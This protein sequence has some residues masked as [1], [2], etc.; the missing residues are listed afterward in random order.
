MFTNLLF[1]FQTIATV[2]GTETGNISA[3]LSNS[4]NTPLIIGTKCTPR[5]LL[6]SSI[7][8]SDGIVSDSN[9][10]TMD[11]A[12]FGIEDES[13][14]L[15]CPEGY[16]CDLLRNTNMANDQ[17]FGLCKPCA[18]NPTTCP[19]VINTGD[20][21]GT[22][23][24][25]SKSLENAFVEECQKQ[26]GEEKNSC[27]STTDC[28]LGL[29]C[30]FENAEQGGY[31]EKCPPHV[32]ICSLEE[33][34]LSS[35][36]LT[37]CQSSCAVQ[38]EPLGAFEIIEPATSEITDASISPLMKIED[39]NAMVGSSQLEATG[40]VFD[41]GLGLKPCEG[42]EGS[43]C[44][45]ERGKAPFINKTR[46]CEAGGGIAA[47]IYN[48]EANCQNFPGS[49]FGQQSYIPA[50]SL[51]H[52]DG[53][54]ILNQAEAIPLETPL[55]VTVNVGGRNSNPKNCYAGCTKDIECEGK[56]I[57]NFKSGEFGDCEAIE[58]EKE[59]CNDRASFGVDHLKCSE[60]GEFCDFK[61]G[62]RGECISCPDNFESCF[63]LDLSKDGAKEC[64]AV[65]TDG[66]S[67]KIKSAPCKFCQ[68]GTYALGELSDGFA[69]LEEEVSEP[70]Q[71]CEP[72]TGSEC[73]TGEKRWNMKYPNRTIRM[74][75]NE[76]EVKCWLVAEFYES[77]NIQANTVDCDSAR[78]FNYI[79]GCNDTP[80]YGGADTKQKEIALVWLPRIGAILSI[81]GSSLMI[82]TVLQ[83][84]QKRKKVIGEL[85][86]L[87]C[88]FDI[89]GSMGYAFASYPSPKELHIHGAQGNA[90]S[91][92]AQGFFIQIGTISLYINVSIAFYYL[93]I[94]KFSWR[95]HTLK[96]SWFYYMLFAIPILVGSIFAFA[97][98]PYY[99]SA[100]LWCNNS[101]IYWSE[102]PVAIAIGIATVVMVNLCW[103]VFKSER[104]SR[105]FR[106][107]SEQERNSLAKSFFLQSLV[108]LGAFYLTWPPYLALQIMIANGRA[109][110]SYSFMLYA[111]T[112]VTLQGFWNYVFHVGMSTR[113]VGKSIK[114]AWTSVKSKTGSMS[115][116]P[117]KSKFRD[118]RASDSP[119]M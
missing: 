70:C 114:S 30:N 22:P 85:I 51:T 20:S 81:L 59:P 37:A 16:F 79:C 1:L 95:E 119:E 110:D 101:W 89:I 47:V 82:M 17:V 94:I 57:C 50:V 64:N 111:G 8:D 23:D 56:N 28:P 72:A 7:V 13:N 117:T 10:V 78:L 116:R 93:L 77:L 58:I 88:G 48:V 19:Y 73:V 52:L 2:K 103:F 40:P 11:E 12:G 102:I 112:A 60:E 54:E 107:H 6:V 39:V 25:L 84:E 118:E 91:C 113:G 99:S 5:T 115:F 66:S 24:F 45:M 67:E 26:C 65:C 21:I 46:N 62:K 44:F 96:K 31:C 35:Q 61:F 86:I 32:F 9:N 104:A 90:A 3:L 74:F 100:I 41:C 75:E 53:V 68:R 43:V 97:G 76:V 98:I 108:Y 49:F 83:D 34:N 38:C 105:R 18:G 63:F 69:T 55:L 71:F 87:L 80:G 33:L 36:G 92:T 106:R 27:S 4:K 29:F 42:A 109:F 14:M 15:I